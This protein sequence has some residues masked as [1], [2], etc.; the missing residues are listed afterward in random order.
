M[1]FRRSGSVLIS[2]MDARAVRCDVC[3]EVIYDPDLLTLLDLFFPAETPEP[4]D[5]APANSR[6]D[7]DPLTRP[8]QP[9][10]VWSI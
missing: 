6:S 5:G 1:H 2:A 3:G 9:G 4:A 8:V 10:K 7:D